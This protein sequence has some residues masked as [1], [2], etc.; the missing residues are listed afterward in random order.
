MIG[1]ALREIGQDPDVLNAVFS[2]LE[3]ERL[4]RANA[5]ITLIPDQTDGVLTSLLAAGVELKPAHSAGTPKP[6]PV[7]PSTQ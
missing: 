5:E 4:I 2:T 6:P 3:V 1:Q 7:F